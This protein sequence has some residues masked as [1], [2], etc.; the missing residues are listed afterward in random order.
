M[1]R[2]TIAYLDAGTG[3]MLLQALLGGVAGLVVYL[4][5]LGRRRFRRKTTDKVPDD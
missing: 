1:F 5:T 2:F 4:R 3:S